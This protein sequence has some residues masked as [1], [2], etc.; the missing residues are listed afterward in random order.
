MDR[1]L[2]A[3]SLFSY[4]LLLTPLMIYWILGELP[5]NM[6][7]SMIVII[8]SAAFSAIISSFML[9]GWICLLPPIIGGLAALAS[10][11][12]LEI[13]LQTS[14]EIY[15]TWYFPAAIISASIIAFLLA[16]ILEKPAPEIRE[17]LE[18]GEGVEEAGEEELEL[19][20]CPSCGRQIPANSIYCPLCGEKIRER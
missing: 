15:F 11:Y 5:L 6:I 16:R 7:I 2:L 9:R 10:N 8:A 1:K 13:L 14:S 3:A 20:T 17:E 19:I 4:L 18:L 12:L